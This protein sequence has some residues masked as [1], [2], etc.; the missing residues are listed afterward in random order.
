MR[1]VFTLS[2]LAINILCEKV[3]HTLSYEPL[4]HTSA[5]SE[6]AMKRCG[7]DVVSVTA[8]RRSGVQK[9]ETPQDTNRTF[10][11]YGDAVV[12]PHPDVGTWQLTAWM[13]NTRQGD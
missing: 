10:A 13:R 5:S 4:T 8:G 7:G 2:V 12:L 9:A 3:L 6:A 11:C 1:C